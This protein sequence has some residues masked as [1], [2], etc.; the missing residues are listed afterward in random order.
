M[1]E[2][3]VNKLTS[4]RL[5]VLITIVARN[6]A[7]YYMDLIQSFGVNMQFTAFGRG[8]ASMEML[9]ILGLADS[10]KAVIFSL[11]REDLVKEAL[12]T[13]EEKFRT[14]RNGNGIAFTVS[15]TSVIG[16]SVYSFLAD[17]RDSYKEVAVNGRK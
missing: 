16:A 13:I 17:N 11:I 12:V 3:N 7:D 14:I 2:E 9:K 15:L 10:E 8:T 5:E 1:A 6:K 4:G